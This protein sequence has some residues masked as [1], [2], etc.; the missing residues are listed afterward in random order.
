MTLS[1]TFSGETLT[2]TGYDGRHFV[3]QSARAFAPGYPIRLNVAFT[4]P[5]TLE[6]KSIGSKKRMDGGFE[7]RARPM[8]LR[9]DVRERLLAHFGLT[10]SC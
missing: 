4:T 5:A 3:L 6:L 2:L 8:T 9:K 7:V 1:A 10:E